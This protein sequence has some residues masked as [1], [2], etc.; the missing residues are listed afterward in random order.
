V[1]VMATLS[2]KASG[3][4]PPARSHAA[5]RPEAAASTVK[6]GTKGTKPRKFVD[7][8]ERF[9]QNQQSQHHSSVSSQA[10]PDN[11]RNQQQAPPH[12]GESKGSGARPV[13]VG[14]HVEYLH[15]ASDVWV[16][17]T[18]QAVRYDARGAVVYDLDDIGTGVA[19][20]LVR[21]PLPRP[22]SAKKPRLKKEPVSATDGRKTSAPKFAGGAAKPVA[23]ADA[24][25]LEIAVNAVV[26]DRV[27]YWSKTLGRWIQPVVK[28]RREEK[29]G[30][31]FD[32][33]CKECVPVTHVFKLGSHPKTKTAKALKAVV[34]KAKQ[35]IIKTE[36]VN[37]AKRKNEAT[38][39]EVKNGSNK[40]PR[41]DKPVATKQ[42]SPTDDGFVQGQRV[43]YY[44]E[45]L[46]K[47]VQAKVKNVLRDQEGVI[48]SFDLDCKSGALPSRVRRL[49]IPD[50][51]APPAAP[52][53]AA[54]AAESQ[55]R[56]S[57]VGGKAPR[58]RPAD[59][60]CKKTS[61]AV[62]QSAHGDADGRTNTSVAQKQVVSQPA[63]A[64]MTSPW[65]R[66]RRL[67]ERE[68]E[69]TKPGMLASPARD[70]FVEGQRVEYY[71]EHLK[72]WMQ[73]KIKGVVR[74]KE[75]AISSFDLD[76]KS[77]ALPSR[78]RRPTVL[79]A[80]ETAA[81]P[82]AAGPPA[83]APLN[84]ESVDRQPDSRKRALAPARVEFAEGAA[85]QYLS[86]TRNKWF[87]TTVQKVHRDA[88][89]RISSYDL[90]SKPRAEP[91]RVRAPSLAS[92]AGQPAAANATS[93]QGV[94][95]EDISAGPK[96]VA[97]QL[98]TVGRED[99]KE[100][101]D[102]AVDDIVDLEMLEAALAVTAPE[103][104]VVAE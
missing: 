70:G 71:S 65:G 24:R 42:A 26:G 37:G 64:N 1:Q 69:T 62:V 21:R 12:D 83:A 38:G 16:A 36:V 91:H 103:A 80:A 76:C 3:A 13:E 45:S 33:S 79:E 84:S 40:R 82:P 14:D 100:K 59:S 35:S 54:P 66:P 2:S 58:K 85:V 56:L 86:S 87:P 72:K 22:A 55:D 93:A 60:P 9:S 67:S 61:P 89:G 81:A 68:K 52:P 75:G 50:A 23:D 29:G 95:E 41:T 19:M 90:S 97:G 20:H 10:A 46:K 49:T 30:L 57:S 92:L 28:Q 51:T 8:Y 63:V 7:A 74:D 17:A 98:A 77:G 34:E 15:E 78:V 43:D 18:V 94:Q 27:K 104:D 48:T 6:E 53:A 88:D 73:A 47:W 32:L 96:A 5:A 102:T 31:V 25:L 4:P 39:I 99:T 11:Q 44:S 101:A